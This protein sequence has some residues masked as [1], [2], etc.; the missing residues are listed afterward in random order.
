M[1]RVGAEGG[2]RATAQAQCRRPTRRAAQQF[3]QQLA[4]E[5]ELGHRE[6][7]RLAERSRTGL[8]DLER[9]TRR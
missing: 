9:R 1:R 5:R 6:A 4:M 2:G 3:E 8:R 7:G